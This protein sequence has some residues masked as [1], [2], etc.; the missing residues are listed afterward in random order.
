[1]VQ[2]HG[3]SAHAD[4]DELLEW[5]SSLKKTP[6]RLFVVHGE[7]EGALHFAQFIRERT[8]WEVTVPEV[9]RGMGQEAV[10]VL[11]V[12]EP[13]EWRIAR[14]E[15]SRHIPLGELAARLSELDPHSEIVTV[16]HKGKRSLMAQQLLQGAGFRARSLAGGIDAWAAEAEPGM[17]RY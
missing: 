8:G 5:L 12:R 14:I 15:G 3:F 6:R 13:W 4:K 2:I 16:C 1:V 11:D 9:R 7:A 17:P 10:Q